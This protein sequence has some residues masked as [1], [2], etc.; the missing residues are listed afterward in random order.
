MEAESWKKLK[1]VSVVC[2]TQC[3]PY[4]LSEVPICMLRPLVFVEYFAAFTVYGIG[5]H[6]DVCKRGYVKLQMS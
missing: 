6:I 5:L 1:L 3:L 4:R 2:M